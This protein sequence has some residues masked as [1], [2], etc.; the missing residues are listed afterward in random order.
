MVLYLSP[1]QGPVYEFLLGAGWVGLEPLPSTPADSCPGLRSP[2][3]Q[4]ASQGAEVYYL[5]G[6]CLQYSGGR[7]RRQNVSSF[8]NSYLFY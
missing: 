4:S 1:P 2:V 6:S 7:R 3:L 5:C 8:C